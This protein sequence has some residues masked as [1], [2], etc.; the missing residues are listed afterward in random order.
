MVIFIYLLILNIK[1]EVIIEAANHHW[2]DS[3]IEKLIET[4]HFYQFIIFKNNY[5]SETLDENIF[6]RKVGSV[7]PYLII[8]L[9]RVTNKNQF[10]LVTKRTTIYILLQISNVYNDVNNYERTKASIDI[11]FNLPVP[12]FHPKCLI[13]YFRNNLHS[14]KSFKN[15][16]IYAWS[17]KFIDISIININSKN[18]AEIFYYNPF[19]MIHISQKYTSK[20]NIF[21][22]K[23]I[24]THGYELKLPYI[25][26]L[27]YIIKNSKNTYDGTEL[28]IIKYVANILN[29]NLTFIDYTTENLNNVIQD[30]QSGVLNLLSF[31][32]AINHPVLRNFSKLA[33]GKI[34]TF[35]SFCV[36]VSPTFR[37]N[38]I[39]IYAPLKTMLLIMFGIGTV[40]VIIILTDYLKI[41]QERLNRYDIVRL[42]LGASGVKQPKKTRD[43]FIFISIVFLS[44]S[45]LEDIYSTFTDYELSNTEIPLKNFQDVLNS[46]LTPYASASGYKWIFEYPDQQLEEIRSKIKLGRMENCIRY[47]KILNIGYI[48]Y[49]VTFRLNQT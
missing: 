7:L 49:I 33:Q 40:I 36:V 4:N 14:E 20:V 2:M 17:K 19:S 6:V 25:A 13:I 12:S 18:S 16:L 8:D 31:S 38:A 43:R 23:I 32:L 10:L 37:T 39:M 44:L 21:P 5:T 11:L 42:I 46:K 22:D 48:Y 15:I 27:P 9:T 29:F 47:I 24:N 41:S 28:R 35:D 34:F 45:Y 1:D 26:R 3:L 30:I